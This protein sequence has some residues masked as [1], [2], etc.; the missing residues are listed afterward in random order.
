MVAD[1]DAGVPRTAVGDDLTVVAL[2]L[3][4][5]TEAHAP[6]ADPQACCTVSKT[7]HS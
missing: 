4:V 6:L 1:G 5:E 3:V 7:F 2:D